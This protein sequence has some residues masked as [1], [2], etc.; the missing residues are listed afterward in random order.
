MRERRQ[1]GGEVCRGCLLPC[2]P[3]SSQ[4]PGAL[5][6]RPVSLPVLLSGLV[7]PT[8]LLISF[9]LL[10]PVAFSFPPSCEVPL[11]T[12]TVLPTF[13]TPL[14]AKFNPRH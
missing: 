3:R 6:S 12:I 13:T 4:L 1:C 7:F 11:P 9:L 10:P 5:L 2:G 14:T 8:S